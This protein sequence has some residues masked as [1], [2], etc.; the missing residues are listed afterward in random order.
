MVTTGGV[1]HGTLVV[2]EVDGVDGSVDVDVEDSDGD[3]EVVLVFD[4]GVVGRLQ[5]AG[6][7]MHRPILS[8]VVIR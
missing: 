5:A 4:V 6:S 3:V 8:M 7:A 1:P 2:V